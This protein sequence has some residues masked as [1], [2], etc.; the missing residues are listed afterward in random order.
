ASDSA[1]N[2][3]LLKGNKICV[4]RNGRFQQIASLNGGAHLAAARTNGV[5]I[6]AGS[7]LFKCNE[8]GALQDLGAFSKENLRASAT[9]AMEDHNGA[10]WIGTDGGG[11]F[12]YT[13][14]SFEKIDRVY[15]Y[16]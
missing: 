13:E 8:Q 16:I 7:H 1:G 9:V 6:T 3:W 14:S 4:F 11:L 12:R 5:W 2:I 10:V 15:P